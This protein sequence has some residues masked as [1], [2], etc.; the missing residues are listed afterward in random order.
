MLRKKLNEEPPPNQAER[1]YGVVLGEV[2]ANNELLA[3]VQAPPTGRVKVKFPGMSG[4]ALSDWAPVVRPMAGDGAGFWA[5]PAAGDQV[6]VAF[7][8]GDVSKPYVLGALW[9][10]KRK[11]P[12]DNLDGTNSKRVLKT[13]AGHAITFQ[14]DAAGQGSLTITAKGDLTIEATGQISIKAANDASSITLAQNGVDVK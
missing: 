7:L 5:L 12:A 6:L 2:E 8:G 9:T 10:A 14:D 11:P 13:P 4:N 3:E 1:V